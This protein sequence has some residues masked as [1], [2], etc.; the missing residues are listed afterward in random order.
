MAPHAHGAFRQAQPCAD[1]P[2]IQ[3]VGECELQELRSASPSCASARRVCSALSLDTSCASGSGSVDCFVRACAKHAQ[4]PRLAPGVPEV[5]LADVARGLEEEPR[6]RL[7]VDD[8]AVRQRPAPCAAGLP[9]R[10]PPPSR[11]PGGGG[12]Q[13][14]Q[15]RREP[16]REFGGERLVRSDRRNA[17]A[18]MKA[19]CAAGRAHGRAIGGPT[20]PQLRPDRGTDCHPARAL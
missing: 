11:G 9:G 3:T 6:K 14:V 1:G 2:G 19:V 12:G 10:H 16:V 5:L 8:L 17:V 7:R 4:R 13:I 15:P 20:P 18:I